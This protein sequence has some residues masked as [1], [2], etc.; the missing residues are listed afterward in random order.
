MTLNVS[1]KEIIDAFDEYKDPEC[2]ATIF[3]KKINNIKVK[4]NFDN[5]KVGKYKIIYEITF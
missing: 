1:N 5:E 3:G 2:S 4:S